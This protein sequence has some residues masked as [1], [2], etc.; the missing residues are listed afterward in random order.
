MEHKGNFCFGDFSQYNENENHY[1]S[2]N[3]IPS[4]L[5]PYNIDKKHTAIMP[6]L[7]EILTFV[8]ALFECSREPLLRT[9]H[10]FDS[11]TVCDTRPQNQS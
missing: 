1:K 3:Y 5:N 6:L 4:C 7:C 9:N 2:K 11:N 8:L 10:S